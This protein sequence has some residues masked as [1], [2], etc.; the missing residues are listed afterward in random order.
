MTFLQRGSS[1]LALLFIGS[2]GLY[3]ADILSKWNGGSGNWSSAGQWNPAVVPDNINGRTYDVA[4]NSGTATLDVSPTINSLT[5]NGGLGQGVDPTNGEYTTLTVN[6]NAVVNGGITK[7]GD[8]GWLDSLIIGGN[9]T[10][11]GTLFMGSEFSVGGNVNNSGNITVVAD[12]QMSGLGAGGSFVNTGT[13]QFGA[14]GANPGG[15]SFIAGGLVNRGSVFIAP[16]TS[17]FVGG[18][19]TD[20]PRGASWYIAG[21]FTGFSSLTDIAGSLDVQGSSDTMSNIAPLNLGSRGNT[22]NNSGSLSIGSGFGPSV[23]NV[24]GNLT[25]TGAMKVAV[26]PRASYGTSTLSVAGTLTNQVNGTLD[27]ND[28]STLDYPPSPGSLNVGTLVNYGTANFQSGSISTAQRLENS[29]TM[30]LGSSNGSNSDVGSLTV[31]TLKLS[32]GTIT[33]GDGVQLIVGSG[34]PPAGF[35]GYEQFSNGVLELAGGA[36]NVEGAVTLDG[37]LDI[38]LGNGEK[39]IGSVYTVL[40]GGQANTL[41][42]SFSNVE[43]LVFDGGFE[44]YAL[45]YQYQLGE[46]YLTVEQNT[47]PEPGTLILLSVGFAGVLGTGARRKLRLL[48]C[49]WRSTRDSV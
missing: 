22:L 40:T 49:S 48:T 24:L 43:G 18:G 25:N 17:L 21:S 30:T 33:A 36:L 4:V 23:V 6:T 27:V 16:N 26:T 42:G 12:S 15:Q 35:T 34:R 31:G 44:R 14:N 20:I 38:M 10:N 45:T 5:L 1:C 47:T 3:A 46:V 9:L 32:A 7:E 2:L 11:N 13:L 28:P 29:G 39:P 37:T 19:V 41:T 8:I